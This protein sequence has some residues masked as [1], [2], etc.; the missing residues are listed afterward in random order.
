MSAYVKDALDWVAVWLIIFIS[1]AFSTFLVDPSQFER[2]DF[3]L[4]VARAAILA[5]F[6]TVFY[7]AVSWLKRPSSTVPAEILDKL[8]T[9][10]PANEQIGNQP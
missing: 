9:D 3:H 10:L 4:L 7:A 2:T 1:V 5:T 8:P 6:V